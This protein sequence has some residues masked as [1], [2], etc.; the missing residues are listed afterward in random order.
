[1]SSR[2]AIPDSLRVLAS[3]IRGMLTR[4]R[5]DEDFQQELQ[6]HLALLTEENIR[7]GM[8][9]EEAR[10]AARLRLGGITQ[11]RQ[12]HRELQGLPLVETLVQDIRY[13][14]RTLWR[15]KWVSL[16]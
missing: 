16:A 10:R 9:S 13:A 12:T 7:R 1:M 11:L 15:A 3:R 8:T 14:L 5:L 2:F 4:C 6:A